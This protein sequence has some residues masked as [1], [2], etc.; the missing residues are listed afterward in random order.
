MIYWPKADTELITRI[1]NAT[2]YAP[3]GSDPALW[4]EVRNNVGLLA[5]CGGLS[6]Y[7]VTPL[8]I[9]ATI[10]DTAQMPEGE[11]TYA[12]R[13]GAGGKML[14]EGLLIVGDYTPAR[15]EYEKTIEYEQY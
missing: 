15:K 2:G 9:E 8:Y 7:D 6:D 11:Y 10:G 5:V 1:P 13:L 3:D 4:L 14:S 12:L